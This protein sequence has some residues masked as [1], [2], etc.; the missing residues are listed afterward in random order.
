LETLTW[1]QELLKLPYVSRC[2]VEWNIEKQKPLETFVVEVLFDTDK[3]SPRFNP[4]ALG[5]IE[6]RIRQTDTRQRAKRIRIVP[7]AR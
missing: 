5:E 7:K 3:K 1:R 6:Q 2:W 4:S